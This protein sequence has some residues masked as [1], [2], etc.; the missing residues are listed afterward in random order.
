MCL[1]YRICAADFNETIEISWQCKPK[2]CSNEDK[3]D[4]EDAEGGCNTKV[5]RLHFAL[6]WSETCGM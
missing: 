1:I 4:E 3:F 5:A 2:V 6:R